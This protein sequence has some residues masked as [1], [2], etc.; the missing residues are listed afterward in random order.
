M[1]DGSFIR[2]KALQILCASLLRCYRV[3][4]LA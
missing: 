2:Q 4:P 3:L 1:L